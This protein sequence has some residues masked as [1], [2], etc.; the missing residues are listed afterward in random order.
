MDNKNK[1]DISFQI[2]SYAGNSRGLSNE[3][4]EAAKEGRFEDAENKI[5]ESHENFIHAHQYLMDMMVQDAR[6]EVKSEPVD[7][8]MVHAQDHL[9]MAT[10]ALDN[11]K[12][13]LDIYK[14]ILSK[15]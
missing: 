13:W 10:L 8:L 14:I 7:L 11:A 12:E 1:Y 6:E 5:K 9:T 15:K 4:I 3:A 2:I